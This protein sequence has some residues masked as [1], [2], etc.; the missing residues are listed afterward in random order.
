M[1]ILHIQGRLITGLYFNNVGYVLAQVES[2]VFCQ[3][4]A[5]AWSVFYSEIDKI[6]TLS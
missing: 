6:I 2:L 3:Q 4:M 5:Q 1:I